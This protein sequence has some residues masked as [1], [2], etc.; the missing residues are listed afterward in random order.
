M[1]RPLSRLSAPVGLITLV[2]FLVAG[3]P[4]TAGAEESDDSEKAQKFYKKGMQAVY[5]EEY[6][7]A[8]TNFKRA[9]SL[10]PSGTLLYNISIAYSR[11]GKPDK[12]LEYSRQAE[13]RDD[14]PDD[15]FVK[16]RARIAAYTVATT[17]TSVG[18]EPTETAS[19]E[20]E[21]TEE[22]GET[23]TGEETDAET[24]TGGDGNAKSDG[25]ALTWVGAGFGVAGAGA[26]GWAV[27]LNSYVREAIEAKRTAEEAGNYDE[28][29][30][31]YR[32]IRSRQ[33]LGQV[34]IYSGAGVMA[35]GTTL[36]IVDAASSGGSDRRAVRVTGG[37][38]PSG[39]SLGLDVRF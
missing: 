14:L 6:A 22:T 18:G 30:R 12:A 38:A 8:I 3:A 28:A 33:R 20:E 24:A 7:I 34:L 5:D 10:S 27:F 17:G 2:A 16:N 9:H 32:E 19:D 39:W 13:G 26:V 29:N 4:S 23:P 11:M 37:P 31:L 21:R 36:M 1:G 35:L 15:T 25:N